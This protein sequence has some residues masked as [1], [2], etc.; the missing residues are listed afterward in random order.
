MSLIAGPPTVEVEELMR[1]LS[2]A[3]K[4]LTYISGHEDREH[5][6]VLCVADNEAG[7]S[8]LTC[9]FGILT[10]EECDVNIG[11]AL[12]SAKLLV[13]E[14]A[15]FA[16]FKNNVPTWRH[17]GGAIRGRGFILALGGFKVDHAEAALLLLELKL[18]GGSD[19]APMWLASRAH[20]NLYFPKLECGVVF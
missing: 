14:P 5:G 6:C 3:A 2:F 20:A 8:L 1:V 4:I 15:H 16:V 11:I 12:E 17:S 10:P 9:T 13:E 18:I 7:R 19:N